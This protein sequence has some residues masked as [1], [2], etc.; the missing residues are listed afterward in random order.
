[1]TRYLLRQLAMATLFVTLA[2]AGVVWLSQ[3]LRFIDLIINR[4]LSAVT[5]LHLTLLLLPTFLSVILPIALFCAVVYSYHRL[6]TD[7]ELVVLRATGL[8]ELDLARPALIL[9]AIMMLVCYA[10]TLYFMP[11]GFREFKDRQ[12]VIRRDYSHILLREGSFTTLAD[13]LTV[14][15]RARQSTGELLGILVHDNRDPDLPVTMMA[16]RG[17]LV[18]GADGPRFFLVNGNRQE[19]KREGRKLSLLYFDRYSF[20]LSNVV[21]NDG[22]RWREPRERYLHELFGPPQ[23][24]DD[25]NNRRELR[26]EGHQRLVAPL[27]TMV[28]TLIGLAAMLAGE[29]N[30]RGRL[31]RM[32]FGTGAAIVFQALALA[33]ANLIVKLPWLS[34]ALYAYLGASAAAAL[35]VLFR[36]RRRRPAAALGAAPA[37]A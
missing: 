25:E 18:A 11:L 3:S 19:M 21:E 9:S 28:F 30:R 15:V 14:Y 17:A 8:S 35:Y 31:R 33:L 22:P 12:F 16:E 34:P 27:Y 7:S 37:G 10:I 6:T 26:G 20:D 36:N 29:F 13:K 1:M 4:G 5:F 24:K 23:S 32:L 2:L